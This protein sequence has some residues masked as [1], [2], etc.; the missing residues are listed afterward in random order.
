MNGERRTL[1]KGGRVRQCRSCGVTSR[2]GFGWLG[3]SGY[4]TLPPISPLSHYENRQRAS[5][6][7][8]LENL[9]PP[10]K[11]SKTVTVDF[12]STSEQRKRSREKS[13]EIMT[14][15]GEGGWKDDDDGLELEVKVQNLCVAHIPFFRFVVSSDTVAFFHLIFLILLLSFPYAAESFRKPT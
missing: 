12:L 2:K 15:A 5:N 10:I 3:F 11:S 4:E 8:P 6:K 9:P 7:F 14:A 13:P 1:W